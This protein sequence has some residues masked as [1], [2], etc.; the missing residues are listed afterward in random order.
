MVT[1]M[2]ITEKKCVLGGG[3]CREQG[4]KLEENVS[5]FNCSRF[6]TRIFIIVL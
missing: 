1:K 6:S 3:D 5:E 4:L 2:N